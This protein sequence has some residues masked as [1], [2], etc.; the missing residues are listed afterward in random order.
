MKYTKSILIIIIFIL[1]FCLLN[2]LVKPKYSET[3]REGSLTREYYKE[4]KN[5]E[6]IFLG[7]CEV[8][9]NFSP[10]VLY[11]EAGITSYVRG[12]SQQLINQSYY[13]LKETL[14]YEIP[15]VVVFNVNSMR[16]D[17]NQ[18]N[19][20]YNR[21]ILDDMKWSQEK[22]NLINTSMT[23]EE[24]FLSYIFP[25]LRYHSRFSK[26]TSEDFTYLFKNKTNSFNGF[27]VNKNI[28]PYT[29]FP[30]KKTL[31]NYTFKS[32]N[33]EYLQKI[34]DL[35]KEN[36]IKLILIKAPSLYP[37]WYDEYEEQIK[38]FALKNNIN[39]Y[40]LLDMK[41]LIGLDYQTDTYDG[42]L[43]LNL[44]GAT[45]LSKYFANIL[46]E[47]YNLTDYRNNKEV[48]NIYNQKLKDYNKLI[49][50]VNL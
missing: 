36:N 28:K 7:D 25:I 39:Y 11:E 30:T 50:E 18:K 24:N 17:E 41:D 27:L 16:E 46:K 29:S 13:I 32:E 26:L 48:S 6:V 14:K 2:Q 23:S 1:L 45:K 22:I 49:K 31:A 34:T 20:A 12:N 47:N 33:Y 42:G 3:L 35:C 40:N 21:L 44:Y 38:D 8:Y 4:T 37:Y 19:E 10:M 43:H 5:H 9:A 15:K